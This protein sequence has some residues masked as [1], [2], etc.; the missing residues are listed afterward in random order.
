MN[1]GDYDKTKFV[2][3]AYGNLSPINTDK[4][5][6]GY[7]VKTEADG[8]KV[9]NPSGGYVGTYENEQ[10]AVDA[11]DANTFKF[12]DNVPKPNKT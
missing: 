9:Y 8:V 11:I 5:Y 3:D 1:A 6:K 2:S 4:K 10:S 12:G 7:T